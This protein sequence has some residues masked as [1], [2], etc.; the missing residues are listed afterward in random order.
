MRFITWDIGI[1][2]VLALLISYSLIIRRHKALAA[3]VSVYIAYVMTS[4][5]GQRV[6]EFFAGDRVFLNQVWI[7][8][9]ASPF[10]VQSILFAFLSL[11]L[12]A[13]IKLGGR[14]SRYSVIEIGV[15]SICTV[16]L[17]VIFILSFMT[18]EMRD[19]VLAG[20]KLIPLVYRFREYILVIPV[21][22]IIYFGVFGEDE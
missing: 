6:T 16:A 21:F 14:R 5:W 22:V 13:F 19:Q 4:I 17:L 15:Y 3:L 7:K 12:S 8:A 10:V 11:L 18:P 9:N 1:L 2:A 20:S